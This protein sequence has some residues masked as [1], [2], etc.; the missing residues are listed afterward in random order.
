MSVV[1]VGSV[2][3]SSFLQPETIN[4]TINNVIDSDFIFLI[5]APV[6]FCLIN[7]ILLDLPGYN[8]S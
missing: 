6:L 7:L 4:A 5:F 1:V 2:G 8:Q 3:L